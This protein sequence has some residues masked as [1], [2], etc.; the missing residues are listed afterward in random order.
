M[1]TTAKTILGRV[2]G[3]HT[4]FRG[5]RHG[6]TV[7]V[8]E[9]VRWVVEDKRIS[10]KNHIYRLH[11]LLPDLEWEIEIQNGR[12]KI[13]FE[14][15]NGKVR[16]V[17]TG[18]SLSFSLVRGGEVVFG[19][20]GVQPFEGW[21]SPTYGEKV[22]ALSVAIEIQKVSNATLISD[23]TF[24]KYCVHYRFSHSISRFCNW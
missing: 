24:P 16:L 6:R 11:W 14:T 19:Q 2:K 15:P 3:Q 20:R 21:V 12:V 17:L 5:V 13:D 7:T 22:P 9:D 10:K 8:Y 18:Q 1:G 23:F 4:G